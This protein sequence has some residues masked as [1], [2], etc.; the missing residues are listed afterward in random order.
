MKAL[1]IIIVFYLSYI[2]ITAQPTTI[3]YQGKLLDANNLPINENAVAFTFAIYDSEIGGNKIWPPNNSTTTK[4]IDIVN[5]LYTVILGSGSGNDEAIEPSIFIGITPYLEVG[6]NSTILPRTSITSVPF[7][8]IANNLSNPINSTYTNEGKT[9]VKL[10][11]NGNSSN[12][13]LVLSPKGNGAILAQQPDGTNTGGNNRGS[14]ALDLQMSREDASQVASGFNST[15]M[16]YSNT[17]SGSFSTAMGYRNTASGFFSTAMG[18]INTAS[19]NYSTA[20][21]VGN[22]ASGFNSTAVGVR[23]TASGFIST[24]MGN[25]ARATNDFSFAINLNDPIGPEVA[26]NTFRIS[27]A[28]EIG[29]NVAWT[30]HSDRRLKKNIDLLSFEDNLSKIMN[31]NGVR[32]RWI[33]NDKL[34]NLGFIAQEV[35]EIVPESV[36]YDEINDIYSMEYTAIIPVLVEGMKEQ[37]LQIEQLKQELAELKNEL[38]T[39]YNLNEIM[40]DKFVRL[41]EQLNE[42]LN[43]KKSALKTARND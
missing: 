4:S 2:T 1:F 13:D 23:N 33:D 6:V 21:G 39:A 32:Y 25:N 9:G 31:L 36:R 14:F 42:L 34:L 27:G 40:L 10:A 8:I 5:G 19:G 37:Q 3:T 43:E 22:T 15:A 38:T 30:N 7:S 24:A 11:A 12:I 18:Y 35:K 20:M 28:T 17:A 26:P 41:S 29:G 16:G